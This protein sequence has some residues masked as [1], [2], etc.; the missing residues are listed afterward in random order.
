LPHQEAQMKAGIA[1][2]APYFLEQV[3]EKEMFI[4]STDISQMKATKST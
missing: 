2:S 3:K 4:F 1:A